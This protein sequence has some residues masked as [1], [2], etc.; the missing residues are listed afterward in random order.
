MAETSCRYF[1]GYKPCGKNAECNAECPSRS[2]VAE[3]ILVVHLE[4]LGAVL[5]STSL[6]AAIKRQYPRS[7]VTWITKAPAHHLLSGLAAIDRLLTLS[8]EDLLSL[9]AMEFDLGL[10]VDKSPVATGVVKATTVKELRGFR[11]I[12]SGA[13]VPA[14]AEAH[15][16]WE[17]GLSDRKKFF[18]NTKTEQQL[19]HE[20]LA[21]G[22][23]VR[24]PYMVAL[25][26]SEEELA[27]TR[28]QLWGEGTILGINTGCS[29]T[30]PHKKL[31][32]DGHRHLIARIRAHGELKRLPIVLLGGP[33]DTERNQAIAHGLGVIQSPTTRGLRDGL[34]SVAACDL[35]FTGDSLGMHMAIALEKWTVAWFGPSCAQEI[36]LYGRGRKIPTQAPC[37]P[38]WKRV[39]SQSRMCYDQVDFAAA[40][41]ALAEGIKWHISSSKPH[42]PGTSSSPSLF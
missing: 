18:E 14:N 41:A 3:R 37:S 19:V 29:P 26:K 16:L 40:S 30:L 42:S 24:D 27:R 2:T 15:E 10:I 32:I 11:T 31:S 34:A 36:D 5:R 25:S 17:L 39:C 20:S 28:R 33:E 8:S 4:A 9:S 12:S 38:C 6:L 35:I 1:N 21:L 23:Y 13:I 22:P 7:S